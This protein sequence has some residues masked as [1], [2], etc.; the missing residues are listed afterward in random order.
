MT[1]LPAVVQAKF[2]LGHWAQVHL[3]LADTCPAFPSCLPTVTWNFP[4]LLWRHL[5]SQ[6]PTL[7]L[8]PLDPWPLCSFSGSTTA[9]WTICTPGVS[10]PCVVSG[11]LVVFFEVWQNKESH[12]WQ[13][14][15]ESPAWTIPEV[16]PDYLWLSGWHHQ[17][18]ATLTQPLPWVMPPF[19]EVWVILAIPI[20]F[21]AQSCLE[22]VASQGVPFLMFSRTKTRW[23]Q[24][25]SCIG[26]E[27]VQGSS[28]NGW[29]RM[30]WKDIPYTSSLTLMKR[31]GVALKPVFIVDSPKCT[32]SLE[33]LKINL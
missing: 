12:C 22:V 17:A 4:S 3:G 15:W 6:L 28:S 2:F 20:G 7:L 26:S 21:R 18:G 29:V 1:P 9:Q 14:C 30:G 13:G 16:K 11:F 24:R 32:F 31:Y 5:P 33:K 25:S 19:P 10:L 23:G 8:S 27:D